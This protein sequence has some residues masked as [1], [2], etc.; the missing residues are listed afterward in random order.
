MYRHAEQSRGASEVPAHNQEPRRDPKEEM[1]EMARPIRQ[2]VVALVQ[3]TVE[4][5]RIGSYVELIDDVALQT[6]NASTQ[7]TKH[8]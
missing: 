7:R 6:N 2:A 1:P 3:Y 4:N 8:P 5:F